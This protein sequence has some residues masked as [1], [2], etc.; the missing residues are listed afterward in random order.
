MMFAYRM[1]NCLSGQGLSGMRGPALKKFTTSANKATSSSAPQ[2]NQG[3]AQQYY[4]M[5]SASVMY[6]MVGLIAVNYA[7]RKNTNP[8]L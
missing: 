1:G 8:S 6:E 5:V 7:R 2:V 3:P 4:F